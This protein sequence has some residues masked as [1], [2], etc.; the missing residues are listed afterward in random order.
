[1][2]QKQEKTDKEA[3]RIANKAR[4]S[5]GTYCI[6]ECKAFC[7][8]NGYLVFGEES[9]DMVTQGRK[10]EL[11]DKGML[12]KLKNGKYSLYLNNHKLPCPCLVVKDYTCKI[13]KN[14]KRPQACQQFP[15]FIEGKTVKLSPRCPAI[16]EN[17]LYPFLKKLSMKG[18]KII[19]YDYIPELSLFNVEFKKSS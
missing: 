9:V 5:L 2:A 4:N 11:E 3:E 14:K 1:M 8:R 6:K 16:K 7:C 15:I 10:K 12:K 17:L 18:Y 13:H 19:E